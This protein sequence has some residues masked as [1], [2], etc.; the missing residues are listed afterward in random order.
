MFHQVLRIFEVSDRTGLPRSS[1][2]AK[3]QAGDFPRPIKL[4]PRSVGWL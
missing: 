4:G 2:Y 1:I 3:I